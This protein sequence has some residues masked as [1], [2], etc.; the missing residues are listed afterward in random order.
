MI[1]SWRH[2]GAAFSSC[3]AGRARR[4]SGLHRRSR[5]ARSS[6]SRGALHV[7]RPG[8]QPEGRR[9]RAQRRS[10]ST[11]PFRSIGDEVVITP[12]S[13]ELSAFP[14]LFMTGHKLV[15]FSKAERERNLTRYV[16]RGGLLFSDDCNHDV[17]G[18]YAKSFEH[19]MRPCSRRGDADREDPEHPPALP[20][21]LQVP[22]GPPQTSHERERLGRRHGARLP[23]GRH[24]STSGMG[25]L[26][27]NK[28]YGCEWDYDWRNKRRFQRDDNT[29]FA[30]Q[31][32]RPTRWGPRDERKTRN[33]RRSKSQIPKQRAQA[34]RSG[35]GGA[36]E[37]RVARSNRRFLIRS[38]GAP[39]DGW[40][41]CTG[42]PL[43]SPVVPYICHDS[44]PDDRVEVVPE[45]RGDGV[46]GDVAHHPRLLAVLDLPER[47][48]AELAVVALLV[49][50][51]AAARR[52]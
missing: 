43:A 29:R 8:L 7:G 5:E 28:D 23:E 16:E 9:E 31:P 41:I 40:L 52:R 18:L 42:C 27:S 14:F 19:E 3:Q 49:D 17:D 12:D 22:G 1:S 4:R 38:V 11:P 51:V 32:R 13:H 35:V 25:V 30:H 44:L 33:S 37:L 45:V 46:V 26:Y 2:P 47:I 39:C 10:S 21:L 48:A 36:R 24:R 50:R 34:R 20:R 6:C 15:R